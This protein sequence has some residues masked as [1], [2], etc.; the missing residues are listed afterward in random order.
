MRNGSSILSEG[1]LGLAEFVWG[2]A[3][4]ASC[5]SLTREIAESVCSCSNRPASRAA[6]GSDG[7][8]AITG[9]VV[10]PYISGVAQTPQTFNSTATAQNVTGL[11]NGTTY[12]FKVSAINAI[13]TGAQSAAS[14][15]VT[16]A[17]VPGA[18]VINSATPGDSKVTLNWGAPGDGGSAI[19]LTQGS[20]LTLR[21]AG[22]ATTGNRTLAARGFATIWFNSTSEAIVSGTGVS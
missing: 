14:N 5:I 19:T 13:G 18:P 16:P 22:G 17:S 1:E 10:T 3:S 12:T 15:A 21:L 8:S 11:T 6:S 4:E 2:S 7:G 20:G 9:Y